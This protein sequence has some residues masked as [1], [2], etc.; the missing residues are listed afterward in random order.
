MIPYLGL[1]PPDVF[2][3]ESAIGIYNDTDGSWFAHLYRDTYGPFRCRAIAEDNFRQ[4]TNS[5]FSL[6]FA[7][8]IHP[9][10]WRLGACAL[11]AGVF[12][13]ICLAN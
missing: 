13:S 4:I 6:Q 12:V 10:I 11:L 8:N 3:E 5:N 7:W 1:Q 9:I 2:P